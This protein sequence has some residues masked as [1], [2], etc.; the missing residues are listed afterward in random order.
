MSRIME[1][2]SELLAHIYPRHNSKCQIIPD[3]YLWNDI[4]HIEQNN[5]KIRNR[6]IKTFK[7]NEEQALNICDLLLL[8]T[9]CGS[10]EAK[11]RRATTMDI[12]FVPLELMQVCAQTLNTY[13][14][15]NN[16]FVSVP[17]IRNFLISIKNAITVFETV[18]EDI[19]LNNRVVKPID[20]CLTVALN[21]VRDYQIK[22]RTSLMRGDNVPFRASPSHKIFTHIKTQGVN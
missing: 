17:L 21:T 8:N 15:E 1:I 16:A 12:S 6:V 22:F 2:Q 14:K 20:H 18:N 13:G 5:E 19:V 4:L 7:V 9:Y 11:R 3:H 10:I